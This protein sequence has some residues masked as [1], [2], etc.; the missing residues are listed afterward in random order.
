[1][2]VPL[3]IVTP[4]R[5]IDLV[6]PAQVPLA[7]LEDDLA[8]AVGVPRA[9][10]QSVGGQ[11]LDRS[12]TLAQ[13][14][15][16][17]GGVLLAMPRHEQPLVLDDVVDLADEPGVADG[18]GRSQ[19]AGASGARLGLLVVLLGAV[20]LVPIRVAAWVALVAVLAWQCAPRVVLRRYRLSADADPN[21]RAVVRR[22]RSAQHLARQVGRAAATAGLVAAL[23]LAASTPGA[24]PL[25]ASWLVLA[26]TLLRAAE[27]DVT[28]WT[29]ALLAAAAALGLTVIEARGQLLVGCLAATM[30]IAVVGS[31]TKPAVRLARDIARQVLTAVLPAVLLVCTG[32]VP[33]LVP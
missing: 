25:T 28:I 9:R 1:M 13:N 26:L 31:S 10:L 23:W 19:P 17:P 8:A 30:L 7:V 4:Q 16:L 24:W 2:T 22:V 29:A 6:L 33:G 14:G 32:V 20:P 18:P 12:L 27:R 21:D 11:L 3:T 5:S 15:A